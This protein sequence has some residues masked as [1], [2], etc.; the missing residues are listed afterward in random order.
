MSRESRECETEGCT[1]RAN[2]DRRRCHVCSAGGEAS[3]RV[4]KRAERERA[5]ARR[6]KRLGQRAERAEARRQR[7]SL[8]RAFV[9]ARA[10]LVDLLC[11]LR[12]RRSLAAHGVSWAGVRERMRYFTPEHFAAR[13]G[14]RVRRARERG[15]DVRCDGTVTGDALKALFERSEHCYYCRCEL[16]PWERTME[17]REPLSRGG[18]HTMTN[19][20]VACVRCNSS[21]GTQTEVEFAARLMSR[22][23]SARDGVSRT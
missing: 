8:A 20:V 21:K 17:H 10:Q 12:E 15:F 3:W 2:W 22:R 19:V 4:L 1:R 14:R 13:A 6:G 7:I 5:A 16:A 23:F 18:R 11:A 9:S